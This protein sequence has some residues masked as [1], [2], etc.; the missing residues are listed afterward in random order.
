SSG[1][2]GATSNPFNITG[3]TT[4][5]VVSSASPSVFGQSVTFSATV[6]PVP[7]GSGVPT[8]IVTFKDGAN[9]LGTG[10]LSTSGGVT[11][12]TFAT[13]SLSKGSHSI[14]AAYAGDTNF[15][16]GTSPA[17]TQTVNQASSSTAL[18]SSV[19]PSVFG[20]SVTLTATVSAVAPGSG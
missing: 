20:Q 9:T 17:V 3:T 2:T 18:A 19:N 7:S 13:G 5:S 12:A 15:S 16:S 8:G 6:A 10:T 14:T 4:T 1:L 11:T